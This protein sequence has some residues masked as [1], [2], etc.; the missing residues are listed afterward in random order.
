[1]SK[2]KT[3]GSLIIN[4]ENVANSYGFKIP[5]AGIGL[6]RFRKN[7]VML[8]DHRNSIDN[9]LG[10]IEDV[11]AEKGLL[12]GSPVF[13][14]NDDEVDVIKNKYDQGFI[15][16]CSMG[17]IFH[18]DDMKVVGGVLILEK[19]EL[20]EVSLVAVPSNQNAVRLYAAETFKEGQENTPLSDEEIQNLC[21]NLQTTNPEPLKNQNTNMSKIKLSAS[22]AKILGLAATEQEIDVAVFDAK[23][24]ALNAKLTQANADLS[25]AQTK[26]EGFESANEAAKLQAVNNQVDEA[27]SAGKITA[28]NRETFVNLGVANPDLLKETLAS[29]PAKKSLSADVNNK[30]G[31]EAMTKEEF[32][33][34]DDAA[35]LSWKT[36]NLDEYKQLFSN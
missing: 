21:L 26:I 3:K 36:A 20:M 10:S 9:V 15:R 7:P 17:I 29:L 25:A 6:Q 32:M 18:R 2:N 22:T 35:K 23:V 1:M 31:G 30:K 16:A 5:T 28:D 14:E 34:M 24:M 8:K 27:L 12:T 19:C 13:V 11:T 33:K 4:D